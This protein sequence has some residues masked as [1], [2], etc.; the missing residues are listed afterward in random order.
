MK[1]FIK[2]FA[3]KHPVMTAAVIVGV[4]RQVKK[5]VYAVCNYEGGKDALVSLKFDLNIPESMGEAM[6]EMAK[7]NPESDYSADVEEV[8]DAEPEE[9]VEEK[10]EESS[11]VTSNTVISDIDKL[12]AEFEE[13]KKT[14]FGNT[15]NLE[16]PD[17]D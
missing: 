6:K 4:A 2:E 7:K 11:T 16:A 3:M 13:W 1:T 9:K 5:C 14:V 17:Y 10:A 12:T 15:S 8:N